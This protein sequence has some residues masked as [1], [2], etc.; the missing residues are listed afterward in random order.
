MTDLSRMERNLEALAQLSDDEKVAVF[1]KVGTVVA[2]FSGSLEELE[3][4]IGMLMIGYHF[5]W[6]VLLLVHSKRTIKKYEK[7]LDIDIKEFF[8]AEGRSA[9]RSMGLDLAKQI[10]N[11]WQ[12]VSGDIKVENRRSIEDVE[13]D[14]KP[15]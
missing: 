10:G 1:D 2:G 11:F 12:V 5:G 9:K 3:K 14:K 4:A 8:P 7:I 6:K 13:P 15:D